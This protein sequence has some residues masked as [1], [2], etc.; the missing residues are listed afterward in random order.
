MTIKLKIMIPMAVLTI[1]A[2]LAILL[3][4]IFQFTRYV[5]N[6]FDDRADIAISVAEDVLAGLESQSVTVSAYIAGDPAI[7]SALSKGDH[8]VLLTRLAELYAATGADICTV[9]DASGIA[10]A[11]AHNPEFFGDD[12]SSMPSVKSALAGKSKAGI[13]EGVSVRMSVCA[14]TPVYGTDGRLLGTVTIGFRL[15][16]N[17]FVDEISNLLHCETSVFLGGE[18]ISTTVLKEDGTRAVGTTAAEHVSA[19][20]LTGNTYVGQVQL[21]GRDALARYEPII[22]TGG[23]P[24]GM[25]FIGYYLNEKSDTIGGFIYNSLLILFLLLTVSFLAILYITKRITAPIRAMI[26]AALSLSKGD[27]GIS[28]QCETKDEMRELADTFNGMIENSRMQTQTIMAIADGDLT[29]TVEARS[30]KDQ[31]NQAIM[32]MLDN[33]NDVFS[34]IVGAAKNVTLGARQIAG[35]AQSLAQGTIEQAAAIEQLVHIIDEVEM[36]TKE[37]AAAAKTASVLTDRIKENVQKSSGHMGHLVKAV[38]D[39]NEASGF[40]GKIIHVIDEIAFQTNILALNAAVEAARAG[41]HGKGFAVVAEEV[42][43]LAAKSAAAAKNSDTFIENSI[44]KADMGTRIAGETSASL[45]EIVSEIIASSRFLSEIAA[46][47]QQQSMAINKIN[48]GIKRVSMVIQQNSTAAE[49]A[50]AASEEM[51]EQ[52]DTLEAMIS[53][54]RLKDDAKEESD[55]IT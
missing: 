16:T 10:L 12:I 38:T 35:N 45:S 5:D 31:M 1:T 15:D 11:R 4:N 8:D 39:I 47:S 24:V 32:T 14:G 50:A 23:E 51:S 9:G 18:R 6:A 20:V 21:F 13:E 26:G 55:G 17:S 53:R 25:L 42:R 7:V 36:Q 43:N 22:G 27:T 49:E 30:D 48:E 44:M 2:A 19:A 28:V 54:F 34:Q 41:Q 46:S 33:N 3:S 52:A 37:N 29:L 40:I